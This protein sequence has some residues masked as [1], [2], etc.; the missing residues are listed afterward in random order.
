METKFESV[1]ESQYSFTKIYDNQQTLKLMKKFM[2]SSSVSEIYEFLNQTDDFILLKSSLNRKL[3]AQKIVEHFIE[4]NS[5][6][7]INISTVTRQIILDRFKDSLLNNNFT[8]YF[9]TE[10]QGTLYTDL[11]FDIFPRFIKSDPF[12]KFMKTEFNS[13]KFEDFENSFL[14]NED[15]LKEESVEGYKK[16]KIEKTIQ[17]TKEIK[18]S[19]R[20]FELNMEELL[21]VLKGLVSLEYIKEFVSEIVIQ[22]SKTLTGVKCQI[23]KNTLFSSKKKKK[24]FTGSDAI[25]WMLEYSQIQDSQKLIELFN[26]LVQSKIIIST[27]AKNTSFDTNGTYFFGFK[28]KIIVIGSG[29]FDLNKFQKD[30]LDY[31]QQEV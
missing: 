11:R 2:D 5:P 4:I 30:F 3:K 7:E 24:E 16:F 28:K 15:E 26:C 13:L 19:N 12:Q 18:F 9:F 20:S 31:L 6:Q 8:P 10:A 17:N 14:I 27:N 21:K 23:P 1:K 22:M 29:N 25:T